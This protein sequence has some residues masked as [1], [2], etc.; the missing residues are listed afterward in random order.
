[1]IYDI[2]K[3][4]QVRFKN[5]LINTFVDFQNDVPRWIKGDPTRLRQVILNLLGNAAKFTSKGE[6]G[7]SV[8]FDQT[9]KEP[10]IRISVK[11][12][13]I[14][15]SP[16]KQQVIFDA[17]AQA[18]TSTTRKYGGTGLGLSI[19]KKL[20]DA[21]EGKI[22]VES[23][24]NNGSEFIISIPYKEGKP[25]SRLP[26][27]PLTREALKGKRVVCVDDHRHSLEILQRYCTDIGLEVVALATGAA[28]A[29]AKIDEIISKGERIDIIL[30]D[31]MMPVM[32]GYGL[33]QKLR[34]NKGLK[35][36][37]IIA[38]TSDIRVG[39]A[40]TA[41]ESGFHAYLPKPVYREELT[42]VIATVMGD[43]R[44]EDKPIV[45]K[46]MANELSL[47][48]IRVLA[49]EDNPLNQRLLKAH[50]QMFG[51]ISDFVENGK[52]AIEKLKI[53]SYDIVIMDLQMPVMGGDDATRIIRKEINPTIPIVA[54][55]AAVLPED[56]KRCLDSGM[57]DYISKPID[58]RVLKEK[59]IHW[60]NK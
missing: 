30:S 54:L 4:A 53:N 28:E 33:S 9:L 35:N 50:L 6:I 42:K 26:I 60:V 56:Q 1:M 43:K 51:V 32:D 18:D 7:I 34:S 27:K 29:I 20:V 39:S 40:S 48:G 58:V 38:V 17:F 13:G 15:I 5:P 2:F 11:D 59:L 41:E 57:N 14:G 31:V 12:T 55:T 10:A 23:Q 45:T 8:K 24:E 46:H 22:W 25:T 21:M 16:D 37:K 3:I 36:T 52:E 19:C 47:K 44:L 49:A